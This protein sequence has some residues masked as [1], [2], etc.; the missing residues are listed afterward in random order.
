MDLVTLLTLYPVATDVVTRVPQV[1]KWIEKKA[2]KEDPVLFMQLQMLETVSELRTYMLTTAIM[3]AMLSNPLWTGEQ[4]KERFL[5][6][7]EVARDILITVR[8]IAP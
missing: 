2:K 7:G 8:D 4:I 6:S 3:S 5:K 1:K